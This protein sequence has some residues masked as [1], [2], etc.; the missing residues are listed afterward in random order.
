MHGGSAIFRRTDSVRNLPTQRAFARMSQKGESGGI[1]MAKT[2]ME[3][4]MV[5]LPN[6]INQLYKW[7]VKTP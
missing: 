5:C 4:A 7:P 6:G 3:L 2:S 1:E